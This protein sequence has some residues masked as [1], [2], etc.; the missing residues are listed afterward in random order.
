MVFQLDGQDQSNDEGSLR[1]E[2][3]FEYTAQELRAAAADKATSHAE[4]LARWDAESKKRERKLKRDGIDVRVAV[5]AG[6]NTSNA[7]YGQ[8][9]VDS[10]MLQ[11]FNEAQERVAFH[12]KMHAQFTRWVRVLAREKADRIFS[13]SVPDVEYFAL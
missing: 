12:T 10:T 11:D 13:L 4:S 7:Y 3:Q 5:R 9:N 2:W 6:I 8:P 1:S